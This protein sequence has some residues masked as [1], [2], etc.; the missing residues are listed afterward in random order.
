MCHLNNKISAPCSWDHQEHTCSCTRGGY[1]F[2]AI[3]KS[4]DHGRVKIWPCQMRRE[5]GSRK[6]DFFP[7][8]MLWGRRD[9]FWLGISVILIW[10]MEGWS[11]A[12][13]VIGRDAG[14]WSVFS[15]DPAWSEWPCLKLMFYKILDVWQGDTKAQCWV[16]G[17]VL[18]IVPALICQLF[19]FSNPKNFCL[20]IVLVK[21]GL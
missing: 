16:P 3:R 7:D 14:E 6:W 1:R 19:C 18:A 4:T 8:W 20:P 5:E 2:I 11:K 21:L 9:V 10:K 12:N 15:L 13:A 17:Q